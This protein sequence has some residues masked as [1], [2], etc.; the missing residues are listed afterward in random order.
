[1]ER[2]GGKERRIVRTDN[3]QKSDNIEQVV[4]RSSPCEKEVSFVDRPW[5]LS[6]AQQNNEEKI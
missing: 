3:T 2:E 4:A 5:Q 1:M 6:K